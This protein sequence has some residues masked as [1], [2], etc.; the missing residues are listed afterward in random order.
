MPFRR[1]IGEISLKGIIPGKLTVTERV[2]ADVNI[3]GE[4]T[5]LLFLLVPSHVLDFNVLVLIDAFTKYCLLLPLKTLTASETKS[6]IQTKLILFVWDTEA[7]YFGY[8]KKFPKYRVYQIFGRM[9]CEL[10]L[11]HS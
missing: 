6:Q 4:S 1:Q 10:S 2:T 5:E 8:W 7:K 11:Y 9:G 3:T